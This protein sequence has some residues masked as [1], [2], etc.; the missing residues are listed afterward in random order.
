MVNFLTLVLI[1][2]IKKEEEGIWYDEL[3]T[4]ELEFC[5]MVRI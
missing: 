5:W 4:Y 1:P 3:T 2:R